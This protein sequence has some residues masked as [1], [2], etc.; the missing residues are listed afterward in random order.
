MKLKSTVVLLFLSFLLA[1]QVEKK[2]SDEDYQK[3]YITKGDNYLL[4]KN[5]LA[6]LSEFFFATCQNFDN[7]TFSKHQ[8]YAANKVD[9]LLPIYHEIK[10]KNWKGKWKLKQ[11]KH[12]IYNYEY[13][14]INDTTV[15][16]FDKNNKDIPCRVEKIKIPDYDNL[17]R[18]NLL[19]TLQF[20]NNEVWE[21]TVEQVNE[22]KRLLVYITKSANGDTNILLD[23]RG[24]IR[25]QKEREEAYK[26]E[27]KT[28]YVLE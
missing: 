15:L 5:G 19:N 2:Y 12:L 10:R 6:A 23:E 25:N 11:L 9:S 22:E 18:F 21:F 28:Y 7:Q 1:A 16:F 14:E 3:R 24:I 27:I 4:K 8:L 26:I 20:E 13:I 17:D